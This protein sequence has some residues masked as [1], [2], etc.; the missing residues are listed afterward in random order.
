MLYYQNG[1]FY[2]GSLSFALPDDIALSTCEDVEYEDFFS[3]YATDETVHILLYPEFSD[4]SPEEFFDSL[5]PDTFRRL[6]EAQPIVC[7]GLSGY[8]MPYT[9][10]D[11]TSCEYRFEMTDRESENNTFCMLAE[12]DCLKYPEI[13][14]HRVVQEL[15]QSLQR[16]A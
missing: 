10:G 15:L 2:L 8:F 16:E 11:R 14:G 12:S 9:T 13:L 3:M 4:D 6:C 7:G 5:E 1:R